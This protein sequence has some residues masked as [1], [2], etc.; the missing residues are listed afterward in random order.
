MTSGNSAHHWRRVQ[1]TLA[2][3]LEC[4]PSRRAHFLD[5]A[6][7]QDAELRREVE[8]LL[9]AHDRSGALDSLA[10]D[11]AP[12][13][14]RLRGPEVLED[15]P[16]TVGRY[17]VVERVAG[18]GMGVV[19]KA[20][21]E[22]LGRTVA[23]KFVLPRLDAGDVATERFR[24]EARTVAALEH[25]NI[26]TIHEIGQTPEGQLFIVMPLYE[27]ET[28]QRRIARGAL[29]IDEAV[30]IAAQIARGLAK[31][32]GAGIVHR[33]VKPSNVFL[34][35]DGTV[36]LLDFGIATLT[37][38]TLAD[39]AAGPIGTVAYM[40]PEQ[41]R[42]GTVGP[43]S[44]IWSLGVVLREMV[45]GGPD[46]PPALAALVRRALAL[47][48]AARHES[49][50]ALERELLA[51]GAASGS[52]SHRR[53][54]LVA[55]LALGLVALAATSAFLSRRSGA[56]GSATS[57]AAA[58]SARSL[59][60]LPFVDLSAD[61]ANR[62]FADG[63]SEEITTALGK[64]EGLR[65][66][67]RSSAFALR[68]RNVD[69]RRIGDTLGVDAVLEGSVRRSGQRLRVT[70][71]LVDART[72]LQIWTS[73]YDREAADAIAVQD[74]IARAIADAL[75]LRLP[76]HGTAA[77][78]QR[79]TDL[80][81]YDLYL[82]ALQL[83]NDQSTAALE[84]A[85]D[86]LDRALELQPDL[87]LAQAAK[88]SV[89]LTRA[90]WAQIPRDEAV[91]EAR[92]AIDRAFALDPQLG[93]AHVARGMLQLFFERDWANAERSLRRAIELNPNDSH[94]WQHLAN[95]FRAMDRPGDAVVARLRGLALDPLNA[96]MRIT[97]G[98][99][100]LSAGRHAEAL[101]A[102]ERAA[103]LDPVHPLLLGLGPAAPMGRSSID[104]AQG[105]EEDA[106]RDLLRTA[107]LRGAS[108][109]ELDSLR[110]AFTASGMKGFW[111]RWLVMDKRQAG[112]SINPLRVSILGA[113]AGDTAQ[114]FASLE[115]AY[116][117]QVPGL[118]FLRTVPAFAGLRETP[119]YL[120]VERGMRFP[121]R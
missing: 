30:S 3:A 75:E 78:V 81:A 76:A 15:L 82:Q 80:A 22:Q 107:T 36:K 97:L 86:L 54:R 61:S 5:T 120:R 69:V 50:Q 115:R 95:W 44:D 33:D 105:R 88:A 48:P 58:P 117:E 6:C 19:Y 71:Q 38:A 111:R 110:A 106:V 73:Q 49:A 114:A 109:A 59:A 28:L 11:M 46:V 23:L 13:V 57:A 12:L 25:P 56:A 17:R 72:G 47:D 100:Y 43:P 77:R 60:V 92:A 20:V 9:A 4:D 24:R 116:A 27:G 79:G 37:D 93:E 62:W 64:I 45:G 121:A 41:A 53:T 70:T 68:G 113:L 55:A 51:L 74:E 83:R 32:H 108:P 29:S 8:S 63:L 84:R 7:A 103:Q 104:L 65:V 40:S 90:F 99:D 18:G 89:S 101:A 16:R 96:R 102:F 31:A 85:N 87:A 112:A 42:G 14:A 119:R 35:T 39:A 10:A 1:E 98:E 34:T 52:S 66:A 118:I 94:A 2:A 67:A 26:C 21:D 91:R